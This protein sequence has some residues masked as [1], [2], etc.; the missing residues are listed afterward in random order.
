[1]ARNLYD[2]TSLEPFKISRSK[3]DLFLECPRCFWL[4]RVKGVKRPSGPGF[5]LNSA[6]DA[7]LKKEFDALRATGEQ[8]AIQKQYGIDARP[9]HHDELDVW[10]ENFKGVQ[11]HHVPTN[12]LVTGAIDDLWQGSDPTS[13]DGSEGAGGRYIVVDYKSTSKAERMDELGDKPWHDSYRRQMEVYQWLLRRNGLDV[14]ATGY[15][16]YANASKDE[17]A[18]DGKLVFALTLIPYD[19]DDSWVE[20]TLS[21]IKAALDSPSIP[22]LSPRCQYCPYRIDAYGYES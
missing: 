6:V 9:I 7:L 21:K 10:R 1:M 14:S 20:P 16:V 19:G 22:D 18:F 11:Y 2:P 8:H 12:L 5:A 17:A 3:I 13:P 4:D 15:W